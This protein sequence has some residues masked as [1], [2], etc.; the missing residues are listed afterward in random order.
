MPGLTIKE[1]CCICGKTKE[2]GYKLGRYEGKVYCTKHLKDMRK[3]REIHPYKTKLG[4][5]C[6]CDRKARSTYP[7]DGKQYCQKHYMQMYH[8]GHLLDRTIYDK[9]IF[10]DHIDENYTEII[11]YTKDFKESYH[12]LIDLDKK[13]L[14]KNYKVYVRGRA[15]KVYGTIQYDGHK[16]LLH[17]FLMGITTTDYD[18]SKT[19]D[20]INGNSL[21]NR[22]CNLRICSQKE[23]MKNIRKD[24]K[25]VGVG[26]LKYNKKWTARIMSNYRSIHIGNYDTY[27]EA[28]LNRLKKEQELCGEYGPNKDLYYII[29]HPHPIDEIKKVLNL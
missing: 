13:D 4:N 5:C 3:Y 14:I 19:V 20:H 29:N 15:P 25:F 26:W 18:L 9:N 22:L 7:G 6:V 17:R 8:H 2:E 24:T 11:T 27:E 21:D 28:V 12:C 10:I 1:P 23:N 16:L